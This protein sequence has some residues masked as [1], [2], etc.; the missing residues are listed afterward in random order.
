MLTQQTIEKLYSMKLNGMA[1]AF[2][3]QLQQSAAQDLSFEERFTL[4]VDQQWCFQENRRMKRLLKTAQLKINACIEDI[5]FK[6][7]RGL[8]KSVI[9]SLAS[10]DWI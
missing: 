8:D 3:G 1:E 7:P 4:L 5:D 10:C 2:K 9:L 6:Y